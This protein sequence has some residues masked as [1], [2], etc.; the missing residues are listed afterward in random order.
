MKRQEAQWL[1]HI[2]KRQDDVRGARVLIACSGGGDSMALLAFL[3]AIRKSLDLELC[4]AHAHHGLRA[5]A[6]LDAEVVRARCRELDLDLTEAHLAVQ[7]YATRHSLG[8][9]TAAR[10]LRWTWLKD[11]ARAQQAHVVATGHNLDDHTE[12]VFLRLF[13]G[14]GLACLAPLNARQDVRWSPLIQVR[15]QELRD[16]LQNQGLP[17]RED[18]SNHEGFTPRNRLRAMLGNLREEA[19]ALDRHL[20]E[21]HE[22]IQELMAWRDQQIESWRPSRWDLGPEAV[23]LR[24]PFEERELRLILA[25]AFEALAWPKEAHLLHGLSKHFH[26]FLNGKSRK[27]K[28]W[29]NYRLKWDG[30]GFW[31]LERI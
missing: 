4:V 23:H 25:H 3:W 20:W 5:E 24:G 22:Q 12:T 21:S 16:Y 7:D 11:Q 31:R 14:S 15:R 9:E 17:W 2:Q 26:P 27:E 1:N 6:D 28:R 13:R 8:I 18:E 10:E 19:P 30:E 29:G